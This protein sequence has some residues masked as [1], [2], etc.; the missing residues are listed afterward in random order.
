[1]KNQFINFLKNELA[2]K[3]N[4]MASNKISDD[5]KATIQTQID[6]LTSIIS[7]VEAMEEG[8]TNTEVVE[9]LKETVEAMG[10]QLKAIAEKINQNKKEDE[11][12][13]MTKEQV[14]FLESKN[15]VTAFAKAVRESKSSKNFAENWNKVLVENGITIEEGSEDAYLP[16]AVLSKIQDTW[17]RN[18]DWLKDLHIV[19][20]KRYKIRT[21]V[22]EQDAETSRAKGHKKGV[23]K[24]SQELT[25]SAKEVKCQFIYK[26]Q[27][28][29]LEDEWNDDGALIDY[30]VTELV[31]QIIYEVKRAILVGDGRNDNDDAKITSI[32]ALDT[33]TTTYTI[34]GENGANLDDWIN[35][36]DMLKND[37]NKPVYAFMPKA[38]LTQLRRV[39]VTETST[40]MYMPVEQIA[41]MMG[42]A[43]IITTDLVEVGQLLIPSDY[44][45]IGENVF[46][47]SMY[48]WHD[49]WDNVDNYRFEVP[50]GGALEKASSAVTLLNA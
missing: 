32:E 23:K 12:E 11:D 8:E 46:A 50:V 42:V 28:I 43:R 9:A 7:E 16:T 24:V 21:N 44:V 19:G 40:P 33:N 25:F 36:I 35:A 1:M 45:L 5:D 2:V 27:S 17:E 20:A 6:N 39:S 26:I 14:N 47:P 31:D 15:S 10:E 22:S 30:I 38:N 18:S 49:G 3:Q 34:Q 29:S 13:E 48:T 41:D 4:L 37:N